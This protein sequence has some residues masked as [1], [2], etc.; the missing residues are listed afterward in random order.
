MDYSSKAKSC[1]VHYFIGSIGTVLY[2]CKISNSATWIL[3]PGLGKYRIS[4]CATLFPAIKLIEGLIQAEV[5]VT[6]K[7]GKLRNAISWLLPETK[8]HIHCTSTSILV[9]RTK[10]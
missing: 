9:H 10:V 3:Y 2:Y 8:S 1:N 5:Q 4:V 6:I 7:I